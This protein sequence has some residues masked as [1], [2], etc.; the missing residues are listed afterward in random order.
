MGAIIF[1]ASQGAKAKLNGMPMHLNFLPS[2][3]NRMYL[4]SAWPMRKC[5]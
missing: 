1:V 4:R 5:M 3:M 2:H